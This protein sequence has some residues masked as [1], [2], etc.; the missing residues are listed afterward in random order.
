MENG[1]GKNDQLMGALKDIINKPESM[2]TI[3][4]NLG[5]E[6]IDLGKYDD[7]KC[8]LE[9][10][11]LIAFSQKNTG[12]IELIEWLSSLN[13]EERSEDEKKAWVSACFK[14]IKNN[15]YFSPTETTQ[16]IWVNGEEKFIKLWKVASQYMT[17]E[18]KF[19]L[20]CEVLLISNWKEAFKEIKNDSPECDWKNDKVPESIVLDK[21]AAQYLRIKNV[22]EEGIIPVLLAKNPTNTELLLD[23]NNCKKVLSSGISIAEVLRERDVRWYASTA[24]R[25]A[26]IKILDGVSEKMAWN[27]RRA[28]AEINKAQ[29][30]EDVIAVVKNCAKE[31]ID[32]RGSLGET[33]IQTIA[34]KFPA[35]V[36]AVLKRNDWDKDLINVKDECGRGLDAWTLLGW[37]VAATATG[38]GS[39]KEKVLYGLDYLNKDMKTEDYEKLDWEVWG[40][41]NENFLCEDLKKSNFDRTATLFAEVVKNQKKLSRWGQ[42]NLMEEHRAKIVWDKYKLMTNSSVPEDRLKAERLENWCCNSLKRCIGGGLSLHEYQVNFFIKENIAI[43]RKQEITEKNALKNILLSI[44]ENKID[45]FLIRSLMKTELSTD[46]LEKK[47][48]K[49]PGRGLY[50]KG[51]GEI[52]SFTIT[53]EDWRTNVV[54]AME[55]CKLMDSVSL[56]K[57]N[58]PLK[59]L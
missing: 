51:G 29:T 17:K 42:N 9:H 57:K 3:C 23:D 43:Y 10:I 56:N 24:E 34:L 33:L 53:D 30:K 6:R 58:S 48:G 46:D 44:L 1:M 55:R 40:L 35:A 28:W 5:G 49:T 16:Y 12:E 37:R 26:C 19:E 32:W 31:M 15:R 2:L 21:S 14:L 52:K 20:G 45:D 8:L 41:G 36:P 7:N 4:K 54:S 11:A 39:I 27:Q 59:S 47:V 38:N 13:K 25:T 18:M 50:I 22:E